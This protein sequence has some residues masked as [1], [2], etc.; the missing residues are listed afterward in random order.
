MSGASTKRMLAAYFE[1]REPDLFFTGMF[2][3]PARNFH[4]TEEVEID[5]QRTDEDIS[6]VL[7]D[8]GA[9]YRMTELDLFTN[10]SFKPP[11]HKEAAPIN[12]YQLLTRE[13]GQDPF[14]DREF[15]EKAMTQAMKNF[16]KTENKIRRAIELQASQV[17]QTGKVTLTDENGTALYEL[18]YKPKASHFVTV[19]TGWDQ[20][21]ADPL[22]DIASLG[23]TIR[24]DGLRDPDELIMGENAL[25]DFLGNSEV[26]ARLDTRR[27]N[28]GEISP[29]QRGNGGTFQGVIWINNYMYQIWSYSA[30]YKD[31]QTGASTPYMAKDK[32]IVK[33]SDGRL[34]A[35]FGRIPRI[36][37]PEQRVLRYLPSRMR[38]PQGQ[39]MD[40]QPNAW[41]TPEG[42]TL[43]A[44]VGTRPLMI[45]TAIDTFGALDTRP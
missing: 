27:F 2:R 9:G 22:G 6:I 1:E 14:A 33:A 30:R 24:S 32:V 4:N 15:Q 5:I 8:I 23:E 21:G 3:A 13:P 36:V 31:P 16:R 20:A 28:V 35:T 42:E 29:G 41:V 43:Y 44:G 11:V 19:G 38:P 39:V 37:A 26:Q 7:T 12:A 34:D 40:L 18:D 17:L 25:A 45:P 10:K